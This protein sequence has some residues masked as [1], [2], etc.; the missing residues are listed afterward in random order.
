MLV[1][2]VQSDDREPLDRLFELAAECDGHF[3]I[4]EHK[5]LDL[6]G[7]SERG[8]GLVATLGT[9]LIGFLAITP[10]RLGGVASMELAV[11]PLHR[12]H[13]VF[14]RLIEEGV[15]QA[16][17]SGAHAVR[18]WAFQPNMVDE[19]RRSGF[20][21]ER[22][23]RQLRVD[24][25]LD[26]A[27]ELPAGLR[28]GRFRVGRDEDAWL[29]VNNAAFRAHP[30]NGSWT[31]EILADRIAQPWFGA[32]GFVM[33]WADDRLA[34]FCWTKPHDDLGEIYVIA[35]SPDQQGRGLGRYLTV[36][37]LE[38]IRSHWGF[39][40][41]MLYMDADNARAAEL[42]RKLGFRLHHVDR[43]L[44]REVGR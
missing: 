26:T 23:L 37:G 31:Q 32:E 17:E 1:R 12:S 43:S 44:V 2:P 13:D 30:E 7:R 41:G 16:V 42:Y 35:V 25:P 4:G 5:Y 24:L 33:V 28:E 21:I 11:H 9:D 6:M 39:E 27:A 36:R 15:G 10:P 18:V 20:T 14:A 34:G 3:P 8:S 19:L 22:E 38:V 40:T 29:E